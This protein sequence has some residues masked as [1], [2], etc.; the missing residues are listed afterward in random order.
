MFGEAFFRGRGELHADGADELLRNGVEP[1]TDLNSAAGDP[2]GGVHGLFPGGA[3]PLLG[4]E[5]SLFLCSAVLRYEE[6]RY[7]GGVVGLTRRVV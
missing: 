5:Q 3:C 4:R 7:P 1:V 2:G 6:I